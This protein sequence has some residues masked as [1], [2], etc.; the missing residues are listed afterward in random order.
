M[1]AFSGEALQEMAS[2]NAMRFVAKIKGTLEGL[3]AALAVPGHFDN[4]L[5]PALCCG[6]PRMALTASSDDPVRDLDAWR[7]PCL[8]I[9]GARSHPS[10]CIDTFRF[11]RQDDIADDR[12]G[13]RAGA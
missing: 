8:D 5:S 13:V 2:S 9:M 7:A 4:V 6:L 1:A 10:A 11:Q 3:V 12:L